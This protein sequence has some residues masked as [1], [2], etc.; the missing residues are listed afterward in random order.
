M[1]EKEN[2]NIRFSFLSAAD[3]LQAESLGTDAVC[4]ADPLV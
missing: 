2:F 3:R 1:H 4:Q